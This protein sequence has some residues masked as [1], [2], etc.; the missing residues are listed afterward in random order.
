VTDHDV[1]VVN[2]ADTPGEARVNRSFAEQLVARAKADGVD[3][4]LILRLGEPV[5]PATGVR[6]RT[7]DQRRVRAPSSTT[8][9][10]RGDQPSPTA[11][12]HR[13]GDR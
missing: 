5:A 7:D 6:Q 12:P 10:G 8:A 2:E 11:F 13:R 9:A 4:R 3:V 1:I